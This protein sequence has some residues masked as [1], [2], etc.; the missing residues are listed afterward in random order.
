MPVRRTTTGWSSP[1]SLMECTSSA[2]ASSSKTWRGCRAFGMIAV[3]GSSA[4]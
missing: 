4:K 2:I 1:T 3:I